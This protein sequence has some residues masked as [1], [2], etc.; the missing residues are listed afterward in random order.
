MLLAL[1]ACTISPA[2]PATAEEVSYDASAS[3]LE[4]ENLQTAVD[5]LADADEVLGDRIATQETSG[6]EM[7]GRL[8]DAEVDLATVSETV[9]AH[10]AAIDDLEAARS[11]TGDRLV[12]LESSLSMLAGS[13]TDAMDTITAVDARVVLAEAAILTIDSSISSLQSAVDSLQ[14]GLDGV[15]ARLDTLEAA[16]VTIVADAAALDARVSTLE[17]SAAKTATKLTDLDESVT[18][19]D[20]SVGDLDASVGDL[21]SAQG[22]LETSVSTLDGAV[23]VAAT[24][25]DGAA[26]AAVALDSRV[27]DLEDAHVTSVDG[28][29]GGEING[30]VVVSNG[31][32]RVGPESSGATHEGGEILFTP[33]GSNTDFYYI[34]IFDDTLRIVHGNTSA[35]QEILKYDPVEGSWWLGGDLVVSG[36]VDA[37]TYW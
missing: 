7:T 4:A 17:T 34:D 9:V 20:A 31:I 10:D 8:T 21:Q 5:A 32:I 14:S 24:T 33:A 28:L 15:D 1:V 22:A 6:A 37:A 25:A 19:L 12:A 13:L 27:T 29:D 18:D 30:E 36:H 35:E 2:N 11:E 23:D 26:S 16:S 3:S